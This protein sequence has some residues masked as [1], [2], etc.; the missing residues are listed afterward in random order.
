MK[1]GHNSVYLL[2]GVENREGLPPATEESLF[3]LLHKLSEISTPS[4][5]SAVIIIYL[6]DQHE[7]NLPEFPLDTKQR[8]L[9]WF[10]AFQDAAVYRAA[11]NT[12]P[13]MTFYHGTDGIT[14][15]TCYLESLIGIEAGY[16]KDP[17]ADDVFLRMRGEY[18]S[19]IED[20]V[21]SGTADREHS[22]DEFGEALL[23]MVSGSAGTYDFMNLSAVADAALS[24]TT[25]GIQPDYRFFVDALR[26]AMQADRDLYM[27]Q[28]ESR[29]PTAIELSVRQRVL[30]ISEDPII[31]NQLQF[32]LCHSRMETTF[33]DNPGALL[34]TLKT[35][36]P[37]ILVLE[38]SFEHFD[39]MDIAAYVRT[40]E[41]FLAMPI[42]ALLRDDSE[43]SITRAIRVGVDSWLS[44]P[45]S[46]AN[47]ALS[48]LNLLSRVELSRKLGGRDN[49]TGLYTKEALLDRLEQELSRVSRSGQQIAFMLIHIRNSEAPRVD[50]LTLVDVAKRVF[51]RSDIL[52]RF[53]EAT[54]AVVLPGI[55]P[56]TML[57]ISDRLRQVLDQRLEIETAV[58]I[59]DGNAHPAALMA[60]GETRLTRALGG[61]R[62]V[63]LGIY[64]TQTPPAKA[65]QVPTVL[66]ADTD[67]AIINLLSFFCVREG[68][69]VSDVRNGTD[70][71]NHLTACRERE[72][73]PDLLILESFLPGIDGFQILE[74]IQ[75]DL[76]SSI[77]VIM[78]SVRPSEERVAKAFKLGAIDFV[79][80]PFR[81]PEMVARIRNGLGR[82]YGI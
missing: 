24:Q 19:G 17:L 39:G 2:N 4:P 64:E 73:M 45:F 55:N 32:A 38:H 42:L 31:V 59:S 76:G 28:I 43:K 71:L 74:R 58:S 21:E 46:A 57:T 81:V 12:V 56:R 7:W 40:L 65:S 5:E 23:E 26:S 51:R 20:A 72:E 34:E 52:A 22:I 14:E 78:M 53:N 11:V 8:L 70:L 35:I 36:Q 54:L 69:K 60:D 44:I 48:V 41:P 75:S 67:E 62:E 47:V 66:I 80:K 9:V 13:N 30:V 15:L 77:A 6:S 68:F 61:S 10:D 82:I 49:L 3:P 29:L 27:Q 37:D 25:E 1:R 16:H 33:L 18:L 79:A 50:F 63:S